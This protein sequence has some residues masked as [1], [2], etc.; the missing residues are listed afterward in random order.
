MLHQESNYLCYFDSWKKHKILHTD[1]LVTVHTLDCNWD[2]VWKTLFHHN[3]HVFYRLSCHIESVQIRFVVSVPEDR[4]HQ[5][6]SYWCTPPLSSLPLL[7]S[8][9]PPCHSRHEQ[10]CHWQ[11]GSGSSLRRL[12]GCAVEYLDKICKD[13][14]LWL[15]SNNKNEIS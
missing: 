4:W 14:T 6:V 9:S 10:L 1:I 15:E 11:P 12:M 13:C 8:G 7:H 5:I 2:Q 3:L